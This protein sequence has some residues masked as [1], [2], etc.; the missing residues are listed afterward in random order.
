MLVL[1]T[2]VG[3]VPHSY[4][5]KDG[6]FEGPQCDKILNKL[7]VLAPYDRVQIYPIIW[8]TCEEKINFSEKNLKIGLNF[9]L[10]GLLFTRRIF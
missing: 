7:S 8:R 2:E 6:N 4:Q 10:H 9:K 5:G 1:K 3:V